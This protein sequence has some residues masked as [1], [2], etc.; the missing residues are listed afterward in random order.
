ML[1]LRKVRPESL[2]PSPWEVLFCP[3]SSTGKHDHSIFYSSTWSASRRP[4]E[5]LPRLLIVAF[6]HRIRVLFNL[7]VINTAVEL[8]NT[9]VARSSRR[10]PPSRCRPSCRRT[11]TSAVPFCPIQAPVRVRAAQL[12]AQRP[13]WRARVQYDRGEIRE[14]SA[15]RWISKQR[16]GICQV[17]RA[18]GKIR[19]ELKA[20]ARARW[21]GPIQRTFPV[22][23]EIL[24]ISKDGTLAARSIAG[25]CCGRATFA[26][27]GPLEGAWPQLRDD[28]GRTV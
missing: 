25:C 8:T 14:R 27:Q 9:P 24:R 2:S 16:E 17:G 15:H 26:K 19:R 13:R 22:C 23:V 10:Q 6:I 20:W 18:R 5:A 11:M 28:N 12:S 4:Q 3:L 1:L 21:V 7:F